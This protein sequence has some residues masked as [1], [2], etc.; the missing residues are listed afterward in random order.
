MPFSLIPGRFY[1]ANYSPDGDSIRFEPN[2]PQQVRELVDGRRVRFNQRNHVQLRLEAIDALETHFTPPGGGGGGS[3]HQPVGLAREATDLLLRYLHFDPTGIQWDD[4]HRNV[5]AAVPDGVAGYIL[6][7]N[8][9]KNGRPVA[10]VYQ[11]APPA[12][13]AKTVR[14]DAALLRQSYNYAALQQGLAYA[15]FYQGLFHDLRDVLIAAATQARKAGTGLYANDATVKGFAASSLRVIT[16][17][18][19]IMPKLFR[20]LSAYIVSTGSAVGFKKAMA[21]V[22]EKVFD[23]QTSNFTHF[24]TFIE[25]HGDTIKLTR[26]PEELVFDEGQPQPGLVLANL[27]A[28]VEED[29]QPDVASDPVWLRRRVLGSLLLEVGLDDL[30]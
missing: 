19:P 5:V 30:R 22:R 11:G 27:L 16:D 13:A 8:V 21:Q 26:L 6:A 28:G 15:T 23:L 1:V 10:F 17:D 20:R 7:R 3:L 12:G 14:L 24:D 2:D 4:Q 18:L 29:G 25:Q 9:E